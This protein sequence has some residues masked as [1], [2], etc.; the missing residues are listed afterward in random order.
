MIVL[1]ISGLVIAAVNY[2]RVN[3]KVSSESFYSRYTPDIVHDITPLKQFILGIISGIVFIPVPAPVE[4]TFYIGLKQGNPV[5]LSM[6]AALLGFVIGS[7][8]SYLTGWKLSQQVVY[9]LSTRKIHAIRRKVNK[10]GAYAIILMNLVPAPS[11]VL[12]FSLGIVK[13]NAKRLFFFL[14][15][16]VIVKLIAIATFVYF[17]H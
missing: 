13:Y 12:S 11:D 17:V 5:L 9:L 15:L 4:L 14:M 10:Y 7:A 2:G 1:I 8:I 6:A 3:G 16:A